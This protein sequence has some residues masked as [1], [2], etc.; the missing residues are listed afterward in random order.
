MTFFLRQD[1]S[2]EIVAD[3]LNL[4]RAVPVIRFESAGFFGF[5][6]DVGSILSGVELS[7]FGLCNFLHERERLFLQT[8]RATNFK[9][10]WLAGRLLAKSAW[11]RLNSNNDL[12]TTNHKKNSRL[13]PALN[14]L[15]IISRDS[16]NR[17]I[18]PV[19][20]FGDVVLSDSFSF[21]IS[22]IDSFAAVFFVRGGCLRVGCDLVE[23][24]SVT[25]NLQRLFFAQ[26]EID[27]IGD[28]D[29]NC[30]VQFQGER[31]W[32][33]KETAFKILGNN[34]SFKPQQ[35]LTSYIGNGWYRCKDTRSQ[36]QKTINIR[37]IIIK[38]KI[39]AIG[40]E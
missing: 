15:C 25:V 21:S 18:A 3:T 16:F 23:P 38:N 14:Q 30:L 19:M 6:C 9:Y 27:M 33:V 4:F 28:S 8:V 17:S 26:S 13:I 34:R 5:L 35:W 22:H 10:S 1:D 7:D 40:G 11:L 12:I 24:D 32:S 36:D 39:L 37:T 29:K 31:I 2:I 20:F